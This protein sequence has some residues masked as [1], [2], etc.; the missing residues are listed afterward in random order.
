MIGHSLIGHSASF[1]HPFDPMFTF[2][3][4]MKFNSNNFCFFHSQILAFCEF[5]GGFFEPCTIPPLHLLQLQF[6]LNMSEDIKENFPFLKLVSFVVTA[7][8]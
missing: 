5:V 4:D 2:C 6:V 8:S 7:G 1:H 3:L